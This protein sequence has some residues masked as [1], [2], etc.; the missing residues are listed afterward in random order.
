VTTT[1]P[2]P[3]TKS[4]NRAISALRRALHDTGMEVVG[5]QRDTLQRMFVRAMREDD[6]TIHFHRHDQA[7]ID[8]LYRAGAICAYFAEHTADEA[9]A[10]WKARRDVYF[11][12]AGRLQVDLDQVGK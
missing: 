6:M 4:E 3:V 7:A 11:R 10:T 8:K 12:A 5:Q 9:F 1:Q 2:F